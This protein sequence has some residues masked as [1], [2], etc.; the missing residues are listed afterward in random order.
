MNALTKPALAVPGYVPP[1][2]EFMRQRVVVEAGARMDWADVYRAFVD[3]PWRSLPPPEAVAAAFAYLCW[4]EGIRV[5][6]DGGAVYCL[7][8]RLK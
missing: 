4:R 1:L 8:C 6:R 5:L 3:A 2:R 7:D